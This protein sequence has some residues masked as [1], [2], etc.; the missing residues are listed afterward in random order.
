MRFSP[1][2]VTRRSFLEFIGYGVGG[3]TAAQLLAGCSSNG[4]PLTSGQLPS[5]KWVTDSGFPTWSTVDYPAML[6]SDLLGS[7]SRK[8]SLESY[9]TNDDLTLPEGWEYQPIIAW[10]DRLGSDSNQE[11][12]RVGYN[13]DYTGLL[14]IPDRP[15]EYWLFVNFEYVS[16]RPWM[17]GYSEIIGKDLPSVRTPLP[18][19]SPL[20]TGN[21]RLFVDDEPLDKSEVDLVKP[22]DDVNLTPKRLAEL[23]RFANAALAEMGVAV[24]HVRKTNDGHFQPVKDSIL[25]KRIGPFYQIN[26]SGLFSFSGP[27]AKVLPEPRGTMCNC[28]GGTTP[29]GTFLTC[30][31]NIQAQ[32]AESV[33]PSGE[34]LESTTPRFIVKDA[35]YYTD[36]PG[37]IGGLGQGADTPLDGRE[38]GWV[39]EVEPNTGA[40]TKHTL[41]GRFRH[42]NVA[43]RCEAG[44]PLTCYMG[45]DRSGG[46]V[47]KFVSSHKVVDPKSSNNSGL[48]S[49]GTLFAARF[50]PDFTG[51]WIPLLPETPL[52][53]PHPEYTGTEHLMLPNRPDGGRIAVGTK[54]SYYRKIKVT[55]WKRVI[56]DFT[57]KPFAKTRLGDLVE[58]A[59]LIS[60]TKI[61]EQE[62]TRLILNMDAFLMANAAG[63]TPSARP[64]DLEIH[65][66]DKSVYI[67]FTDCNGS[68][69]GAP[70]KRI[71][72][73]GLEH[74]ERSYGSIF[75][76]C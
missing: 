48:F 28:S 67:A 9:E 69:G 25:N 57:G 8:Q 75:R 21:P 52:G 54:E 39:C 47:W 62:A 38:Y 17:Q 19:L 20:E 59:S 23:R 10:G 41:L 5:G 66:I 74:A 42:E 58:P 36:L 7:L 35:H 72:P 56:E 4:I 51:E 1:E 61:T 40:L 26:T 73:S 16:P 2:R 44:L 46:H 76:V 63:A 60:K 22:K 49:Q 13:C 18:K 68:G 65:P 55:E 71:F 45:D 37:R 64:E 43:V 14:P 15:N 31:E 30:E 50:N 53:V 32:V 3:I 29:W 34:Q 27:G 6:R 70:D 11:L 12:F 33:S 24:V